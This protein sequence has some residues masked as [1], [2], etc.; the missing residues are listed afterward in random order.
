MQPRD[1][2]LTLEELDFVP[3]GEELEEDEAADT[4]AEL[5]RLLHFVHAARFCGA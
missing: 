3:L 2:E 5:E 4:A 1:D